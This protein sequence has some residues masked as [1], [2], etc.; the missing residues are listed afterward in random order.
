MNIVPKCIQKSNILNVSRSYEVGL[1]LNAALRTLFS[2]LSKRFTI[3]DSVTYYCSYHTLAEKYT[4]CRGIIVS[5]RMIWSWYTGRWWV[6]CYI[7]YSEEGTGRGRSPPRPL[8]A[9][10]NVTVHP[11]TASV[12]S[13]VKNV[14]R[15]VYTRHTWLATKQTLYDKLLH[16]LVAWH[17]GRTSVFD[18]RTELSLSRA[19]AAADGWPLTWVNR[20]LYVSQPGRLSLSS[21]RE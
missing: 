8:L 14:P 17:S 19:W 3:F 7:W 15:D 5:H 16:R 13:L 1:A 18:W 6:G 4:E 20:P 21:F 12:S 9:V 2:L 11:S 10:P